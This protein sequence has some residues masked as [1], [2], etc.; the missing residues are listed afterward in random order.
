MIYSINSSHPMPQALATTDSPVFSSLSLGVGELTAGS[1][2]RASGHLEFD[3]GGV[4]V[5]SFFSGGLM[6]GSGAAGVD[7]SIVA[8]DEDRFG[9]I[10]WNGFYD[11]WVFTDGI[12]LPLG[13]EITFGTGADPKAYIRCPVGS[14]PQF[15]GT[16]HTP[17]TIGTETSWL[18]FYTATGNAY[19]VPSVDDLW[20]LGMSAIQF[21]NIY[22]DGKAY[23][24]GFGEDTL[25]DSAEEIRFRATTQRIYSSA[26]ST[27]DLD[28]ATTL[29]LRVGGTVVGAFTATLF[30]MSQDVLISSGKKINFKNG[31]GT[32]V[33]S[34]YEDSGVRIIGSDNA[35]V[36]IGN[37]NGVIYF[38][39]SGGAPF[40]AGIYPS[41]DNEFDLGQ[42][43]FEFR[44]LFIDGTAYID[45]FG[46]DTLFDAA[47]GVQ[48]RA[49]GQKVYSSAASTLD[50]DSATTLNLRIGGTSQVTLIDG[51]LSPTTDED[52]DL[53]TSSQEFK[54]IWIDGKAYID[55]LG[56]HLLVGEDIKIYFDDTS[57]Y[58]MN[59]GDGFIQLVGFEGV[60]VDGP[61][62]LKLLNYDDP[63][64]DIYLLPAAGNLSV[65]L[66]AASKTFSI[67]HNATKI[68]QTSDDDVTVYKDLRVE[69]KVHSVSYNIVCHN[70]NVV[71]HNDEVVTL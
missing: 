62:G 2:N 51:S 63:G 13:E 50:L 14:N 58:I 12:A 4:T 66:A 16:G 53:G 17:I 43:A 9:F 10:T 24:D 7:Y 33:G 64:S 40:V 60:V 44:N 69:E 39:H 65:R 25:F 32:T 68:L 3:I 59:D 45:S 23:I 38:Q 26:A 11:Y 57:S 35:L 29:N 8:Y 42:A 36:T 27:L 28:T 30:T 6:I 20:D 46:E 55:E 71:C 54:D 5:G 22:I 1:V 18:T 15:I 19:V 47:F 37:S 70:N 48:F 21:R 41:V 56:E 61:S 67:T 49:S 31:V 52:V 34:I